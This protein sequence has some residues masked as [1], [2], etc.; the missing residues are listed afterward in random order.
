M[1]KE[2]RGK[3]YYRFQ[4]DD[5]EISNKMKRRE[6][7]KLISWGVNCQHWIYLA[8]FSRPDIAKKVFKT[9]AGGK[10]DFDIREEIFYSE[11]Y[12]LNP[13]KSAA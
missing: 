12:Q 5:K 2:E 8:E 7:F 10:I 13:E 9:I 11:S 4:T 3:P 1:W 6:K